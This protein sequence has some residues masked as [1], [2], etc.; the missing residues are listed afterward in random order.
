[1]S[2]HATTLETLRH[3]GGDPA[4]DFVN[5]VHHWL[6]TGPQ[7]EYLGSYADLLRWARDAG[8]VDTRAARA[9]TQAATSHPR[10]AARVYRDALILRAAIHEVMQAAIVRR[11]ADAG[12]ARVFDAW[13]RRAARV[14][15]IAMDPH[16]RFSVEWRF[17]RH[18]PLESPLLKLAW[19][20]A[21]FLL[22][23][24]PRRLK[25]CPAEPGCGWLF[26]DTSKNRSRR[27]CDMRDCGNTA[28]ARRHYARV[29]KA[30]TG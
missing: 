8:V 19:S 23:V 24:E 18:L 21:R 26:H 6:G 10:A 16:G 4:L 3:V 30:R 25:Q 29:R 13:Y 5:T 7:R 12:L 1:M 11:G 2:T 17:D 14:R 28:K 27:W 15:G 20:A 9:L 22:T